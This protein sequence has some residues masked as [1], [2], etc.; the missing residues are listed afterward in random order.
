[1]IFIFCGLSSA[2]DDRVL[3]PI[4]SKERVVQSGQLENSINTIQNSSSECWTSPYTTFPP[5][6]RNNHHHNNN[7]NT[8]LQ[9]EGCKTQSSETTTKK[10]LKWF[11]SNKLNQSSIIEKSGMTFWSIYKDC[12]FLFNCGKCRFIFGE[13]IY[14]L[15]IWNVLRVDNLILTFS[16]QNIAVSLEKFLLLQLKFVNFKLGGNK[17]SFHINSNSY[18]I[19]YCWCRIFLQLTETDL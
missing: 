14:S 15:N 13:K 5:F 19:F 18:Q 16:Q 10:F 8:V 4:V 3:T 9:L 2:H 17:Q 11:S 1:M 7:S 6:I 12:D